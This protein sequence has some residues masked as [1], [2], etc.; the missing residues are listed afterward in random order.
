[1][2]VNYFETFV[3]VVEK[4]SFSEAART[5]K[6]SQPAISFQIQALE[7]H[8]G[9]PLL[10]RSG[11]RVRLTAAGKVLLEHARK[12]VA[13]NAR[14]E[15]AIDQLRTGLR[16]ELTI[17]ASTIPGEYIVPPIIGRFKAMYPRVKV[18]LNIGDTSRTIDAVSRHTADLGFVGAPPPARLKHIKAVPVASDKLVLLTPKDHPWGTRRSVSV[19]ELLDQPL[20]LREKGSGT[21]ETFE[22]ALKK[23]RLTLADLSVVMELGSNQAVLSAVEAGLGVSVL[24]R[25]AAH[26]A[27]RLG[28][29][30]VL[31]AT[32]LSL[33]RALYLIYD[34]DRPESRI[35]AV[36]R[37]MA[38]AGASA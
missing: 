9:E 4:G 30:R 23:N 14:L 19:Q 5:L 18:T 3:T 21:R 27:A 31:E 29:V 26:Q 36:F 11:G 12:M 15:R 20:V 6:M 13:L 38:L 37:E 16:G 17:E 25:Y 22:K 28:M 35:Q 24:S 8:F 1:M 2:N 34:A 10:D 32:G 33:E 7:K